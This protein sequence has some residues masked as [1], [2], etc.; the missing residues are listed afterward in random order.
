MPAITDAEINQRPGAKDKWLNESA[1]WG[2]GSLAVRITT[3]GERLFYFRYSKSD[4]SRDTLQ[5]GAYD[6][7]GLN[8]RFTLAAARARAQELANIHRN[9]FLDVREHLA[10]EIAAKE[11]ATREIIDRDSKRQ[12]AEEAEAARLSSRKT[13]RDAFNHWHAVDLKKRKDEGKAAASCFKKNVL[14]FLGDRYIADLK[15][16]DILEVIDQVQARG[17]NGMAR[18][19]FTLVRQMMRFAHV[20]D[21]TDSEPTAVL[22]KRK[23]FGKKYFRDRWLSEAEIKEL[24]KKLPTSGLLESA[25][26]A[27]W[28][29]LSTCCRIGELMK[30]RWMH[31][32]FNEG[33]WYI[34]D[35]KNGR[36][37]TVLL[38]PFSIEQFKKLRAL[39]GAYEWCYPN[40]QGTSHVDIKTV[41]KQITDRQREDGAPL[42]NRS[43]DMR[44]L[45]LTGGKWHPHDLRRTA[46]TL[47]TM[48]GVIPEVAE[49]CLNHVEENR[50]KLTYQ[51]YGYLK[52]MKE[53]WRVLGDRLTVLVEPDSDVAAQT[54]PIFTAGLKIESAP[55]PS[56][57]TIHPTIR[58]SE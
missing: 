39:H 2:H 35:T 14:P 12:A 51:R 38:S 30:A 49:K 24:A 27:P 31:I 3:G 37:H 56:Y 46:A 53:A 20:R 18:E 34:P 17:S 4:R 48:L 40:T 16:G 29:I 13:V 42:R 9:G 52:E 21:W 23:L 44:A 55:L 6:K 5:I 43:S 11:A 58:L 22:D 54:D 41:T 7:R 26:L 45:C 32:D 33:T 57:R 10:A 1:I 19:V 15:R 36:P 25:Q 28:I 8:G 50:V 47:M